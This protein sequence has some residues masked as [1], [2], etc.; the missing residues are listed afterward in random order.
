LSNI[1]FN[2]I[3]IQIYKDK[4]DDKDFKLNDENYIS[5][6]KLHNSIQNLIKLIFDIETFK[7]QMLEFEVEFIYF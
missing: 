1:Y 5:T 2:L 6:S 3:E 4:I 7:R